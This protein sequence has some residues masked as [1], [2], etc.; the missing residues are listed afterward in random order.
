[1]I[2]DVVIGPSNSTVANKSNSSRGYNF[3]Y[4]LIQVSFPFALFASFSY[5]INQKILSMIKSS[6]QTI[7]TWICFAYDIEDKRNS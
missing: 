4:V 7:E 2:N 6:K 1:M 5:P 3:L